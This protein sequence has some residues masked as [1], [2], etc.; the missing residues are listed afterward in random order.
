MDYN[1]PETIGP[2]VGLSIC[3]ALSGLL[4]FMLLLDSHYK[5]IKQEIYTAAFGKA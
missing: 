2:R 3:F 1:T 4:F 5:A